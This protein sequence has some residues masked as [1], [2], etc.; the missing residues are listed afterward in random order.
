MNYKSLPKTNKIRN[1]FELKK[2]INL[3]LFIGFSSLASSQ[4]YN[5]KDYGAIGNATTLDTK[6]IQ[7]A[8]ET[9][10][11]AGGGQVLL[12]PGTYKVGG[13]ELK[14]NINLH[15][16]AGAI[17]LGSELQ[18]DYIEWHSKAESRTVIY[19]NKFVIYAN[20]AKNISITGQGVIHGNGDDYFQ[21]TAPQINRPFLIQLVDCKNVRIRD[22]QMLESANWT[23]H[24]LFCENVVIDGITLKNSTRA[25]RDGLDI[26][27]CNNVI[28]TNSIVNSQDDAIVLKASGNKVCENIKI[29]NCIVS[30]EASAIKLGT[31]S[32]GGYQNI[33]ISDC[34]IKNVP[35]LSGL[36]I[37]SV[38][39]AVLDNLQISNIQME[40][41]AT[42]IFLRLGNRNRP[43]KTGEYVPSTATI[44]NISF[45]NINAVNA[46]YPS[47]IAGLHSKKIKDV[48][49]NNFSVSYKNPFQG[50]FLAPNKIPFNDMVYPSALIFGRNLPT[51]AFYIRNIENIRMSNIS[52][53][54]KNTQKTQPF[55]FDYIDNLKL[56]NITAD[57]FEGENSVAYLR[58]IN[59]L[60]ASE[61]HL[62]N[63]K[64]NIFTIEK[65]NCFDIN[66]ENSSKSTNIKKVKTLKDNQLYAT[67]MATT[68]FD[69]EGIIKNKPVASVNKFEIEGKLI[70]EPLPYHNLKS[71]LKIK[72]KIEGDHNSTPQLCFL[73]K[74]ISPK[75]NNYLILEYEGVEQKVNIEWNR[76]GW[77]SLTLS[78]KIP[79]GSKI[80]FKLAQDNSDILLSKVYLRYLNLGYTD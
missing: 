77:A 57:T 5:V 68:F 2:L 52:I 27:G 21:I 28:I 65:E 56:K 64:D 58:N 44:S 39:G 60:T 4:I 70:D 3:F 11:K 41:V 62:K 80:K 79:V 34:T 47:I 33:T 61:F 69:I 42:P 22:V 76:W 38:D 6:A 43:Y 12:P 15:I 36:S 78:K 31:E 19:A 20:G 54:S 1:R 71:P 25:N 35:L 32:S 13:I 8:I 55:L 29:S 26:D 66:L 73:V 14:D 16:S 46:K 50:P 75:E 24:L 67:V 23:C 63:E 40:N 72:F 59:G 7:Q 10:F 45:N 9:A 49:I 53:S 74:N 48:T 17:L 37:M 51:Y 18:R 30:T